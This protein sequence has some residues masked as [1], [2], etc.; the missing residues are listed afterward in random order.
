MTEGKEVTWNC[1]QTCKISSVGREE[2]GGENKSG[3]T[4][5]GGAPITEHTK[6]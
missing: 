4:G 2:G 3:D 1:S 6:L 5:K